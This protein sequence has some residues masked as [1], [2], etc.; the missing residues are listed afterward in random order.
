MRMV[1]VR[2]IV[3]VGVLMLQDFVLVIVPVRFH[4][5]EDDPR[6]HQ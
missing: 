1:V 3:T 4:E 6:Q 5:M 2:V